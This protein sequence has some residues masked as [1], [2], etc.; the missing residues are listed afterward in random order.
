MD[1]FLI[2]VARG[3]SFWLDKIIYGFIPTVYN[4]FTDIAQTTI[5]S[6]DILSLFSSRVYSLLGIFML[7]KVS[8]SILTYIVDPDAFLDKSKGFGKL[9]GNVLITLVLLVLTPWI[10]KQAMEIQTIILENNV[11]G[12]LFTVS[13]VNTNVVSDPGNTM[14]YETFNAFYHLD[15][16]LSGSCNYTGEGTYEDFIS[17]C[18]ESLGI[19]DKDA[20]E[21]LKQNLKFSYNTN[22]ISVYMDS[23]FLYLKDQNDNYVMNYIPIISTLAGGAIVLLLIVFCFDIAVRSIKLGFLRMLA[24]IPIISRIDPK[25]G[26]EV[27]DK[28]LKTCINTYLDLFIRLLAIYFAIFVITQVI[29]LETYDAVTESR[30]SVSAF[31]KVFIILGALLFAKQLPKLIEEITGVKMDGKFTLNP[32]SKLRQVPLAGAAV[33]TAA[34]LAGGAYTGYKAGVQAG[35]P[36]RGLF[37]GMMGAR[38]EIKGKVPLMG[39]EKGAKSPRALNSGMQA[40]YKEITGK[41]YTRYSPWKNI[42]HDLG[43]EEIDG[44]KKEK[45][46]IQGEQAKLDAQLQSFYDQ[47]TK[48]KTAEERDKINKAIETNRSIYG[49]YS[50]N[51][52]SIDDQ[53]K[54]IKRLYH[55]DD[56]PKKDVDE[57]R[58]AAEKIL[59]GTQPRVS[60]ELTNQ[61]KQENFDNVVE[62][63]YNDLG[64]ENIDSSPGLSDDNYF[65]SIVK[66]IDSD[67]NNNKSD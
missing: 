52:S 35:H 39:A 53:I 48:A 55:I 18:V 16:T 15:T 59:A 26:K 24:P 5:F 63:I 6:T 1:D 12:K 17:G 45:Y 23:S 25:K 36:G 30:V 19:N 22:S 44:L 46:A 20:A 43:Q 67:S 49:K 27:F 34:A 62:Q 10:F 11:I 8:F 38:R 14:A 60:V 4:L 9:I 2:W 54:D 47:L 32:M 21:D 29:S 31:V 61:S 40:G 57:A 58:K 51:I 33:T 28:W 56:S 41:D 65:E 50:K 66:E 42:G 7:F 13:N 3:L 64:M 37:Q